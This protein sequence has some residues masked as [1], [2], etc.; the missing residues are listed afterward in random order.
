MCALENYLPKEACKIVLSYFDGAQNDYETGMFGLGEHCQNSS[1]IALILFGACRKGHYNMVKKILCFKQHKMSQAQRQFFDRVSIRA[2]NNAC[3]GGH[4]RIVKFFL[5]NNVRQQSL[6]LYYAANNG[7]MNIINHLLTTTDVCPNEGLAGACRAG[8]LPLAIMFIENGASDIVRAVY[9]AC[10]GGH[11]E[12][13]EYFLDSAYKKRD[14]TVRCVIPTNYNVK[15]GKFVGEDCEI[16]LQNKNVIKHAFI[17]ACHGDHPSIM[18]YL[19]TGEYGFL[20]QNIGDHSRYAYEYGAVN[21]LKFLIG[22]G[23]NYSPILVCQLALEKGHTNMLEYLLSTVGGN[24]HTITTELNMY[25][26]SNMRNHERRVHARS[27][28]FVIEKMGIT[29]PDQLIQVVYKSNDLDAI[30]VLVEHGITTHINCVFLDV[31][32]DISRIDIIKYAYLHGAR[33]SNY[34][35]NTVCYR[36]PF[37]LFKLIIDNQSI[38]VETGFTG[39]CMRGDLKFIKCLISKG[40]RDFNA[41]LAKL[42]KYKHA[43]LMRYMIDK[44]ATHCSNCKL[45]MSEHRILNEAS[46]IQ[47]FVEKRLSTN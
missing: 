10:Y 46:I 29:L 9:E 11:I 17:C 28:K 18:H 12:L 19:R 40:A 31:D 13:I 14:Y 16:Y 21:S 47:K 24:V 41:G 22:G 4:L 38:D 8:N 26:T 20:V 7:R 44:G 23:N 6:G 30:K 1:D 5:R 34:Y 2:Y 42:C 37:K 39:A 15:Y 35:S 3:I 32:V 27:L 45:D 25:T 33:C 43:H 36:G